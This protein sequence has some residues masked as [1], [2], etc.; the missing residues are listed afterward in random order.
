VQVFEA[1][2]RFRFSAGKYGL[3][4]VFHKVIT[5]FRWG[6]CGRAG[7]SAHPGNVLFVEII[8]ELSY[9]LISRLVMNDVVQ[10]RRKTDLNVLKLA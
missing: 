5:K 6:N 9:S 7:A 1:S 4:C 10:K 8:K 3:S 2:F